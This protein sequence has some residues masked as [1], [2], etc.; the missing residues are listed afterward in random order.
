MQEK[1]EYLIGLIQNRKSRTKERT[2]K[3]TNKQT[4]SMKKG[5]RSEKLKI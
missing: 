3:Q 1:L 2:D 4:K 5:K